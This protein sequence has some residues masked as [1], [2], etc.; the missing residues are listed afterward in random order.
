MIIKY[1][2]Y[3]PHCFAFGGFELQMLST[4][5]AVKAHGLNIQKMDVWDRDD[6]FDILHCWGLGIGNYENIHW[7]K[8]SKKKIVVTALSTHIETIKDIAK[9][10]ISSLFYK[11]RLVKEMVQNIDKI[12]VLNDLQADLYHKFFKVPLNKVEIIPNIVNNVFFDLRDSSINNLNHNYILCVGNICAR[13]NQVMLADACAAENVPL[14]LIGKTISGEDEYEKKL[15]AL[16]AS[17]PNIKW[18]KGLKENSDQ[19]LEY[20]VNCKALALPSFNEQQPI[21]LLEA[22]VLNKPLIIADQAYARQKYYTNSCLVDPDSLLEIKRG[23]LSVMNN[24]QKYIPDYNFLLEC[25]AE[26]V[27]ISYASVY[28]NLS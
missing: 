18:I 28:N 26:N 27:A 13:K 17:N 1:V 24:P 5:D 15:E 14:V 2:P 10:T 4:Y 19:L 11:Q 8:K 25:K 22:A 6:K 12:V 23:L 16:I 20:F 9:F 7:A 21:S 3:Q